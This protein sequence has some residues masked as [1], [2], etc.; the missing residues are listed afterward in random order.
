MEEF[1]QVMSACF[2]P[3]EEN[4]LQPLKDSVSSLYA[5]ATSWKASAVPYGYDADAA[6]PILARLL[7]QCVQLR[8]SV[9]QKKSDTILKEQI[10]AAHETFHEIM[11]KCQVKNQ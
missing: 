5:K 3:A 1:H 4:N 7:N 6:K 8:K 11:E 10:T 2:H 9:K